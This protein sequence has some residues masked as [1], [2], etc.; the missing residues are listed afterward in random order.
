MTAAH[1]CNEWPTLPEIAS[2]CCLSLGIRSLKQT[3]TWACQVCHGLGGC[4]A[5]IVEDNPLGDVCGAGVEAEV[6]RNLFH[7]FLQ[8]RKPTT[9][10]MHSGFHKRDYTNACSLFLLFQANL[11]D[12]SQ[13]SSEFMVAVPA[14]K[15]L[16]T[17]G[18]MELSDFLKLLSMNRELLN[19]LVK[20]DIVSTAAGIV[21]FQSRAAKWYAESL[22][23]ARSHARRSWATKI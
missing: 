13:G 4:P 20:C 2:H 14:L 16:A 21:R 18:S 8:A 11:A 22:P 6:K 15:R 7:L 9:P 23:A 10:R 3:R 5:H 1:H 17:M 19:T 12:G